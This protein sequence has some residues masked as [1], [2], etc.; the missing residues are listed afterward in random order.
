MPM[1]ACIM[2]KQIVTLFDF[3]KL[4]VHREFVTIF[5]KWP[6]DIVQ[7]IAGRIFFSQHCNMMVSTV[8]S[9]THQIGSTGIGTNIFFVNMFLMNRLCHQRS[10]RS[11]H[12]PA[13]L[14]I[15]RHIPHVCRKKHLFIYLTDSFSDYPNIIWLLLRCIR[16]ADSAGQIDKCNMNACLLF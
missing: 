5:T 7:V 14:C 1:G 11:H 12:I 13:K 8:D 15:K 6:C 3:R 2:N 10:I 16:N 4:P 9:R